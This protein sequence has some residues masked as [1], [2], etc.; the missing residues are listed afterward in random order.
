MTFWVLVGF[1]FVSIVPSRLPL[2]ECLVG[3]CVGDLS[4]SRLLSSV[5]AG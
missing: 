3:W 1:G 4:V 5:V 2:G